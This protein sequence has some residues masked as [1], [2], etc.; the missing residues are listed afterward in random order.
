MTDRPTTG[1]YR[2][3]MLSM[4]EEVPMIGPSAAVQ[5]PAQLEQKVIEAAKEWVGAELLAYETS[6]TDDFERA[7]DRRQAFLAAL[8]ELTKRVPE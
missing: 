6:T 3:K 1:W 5:T 8:R 7:T 2:Q 4:P